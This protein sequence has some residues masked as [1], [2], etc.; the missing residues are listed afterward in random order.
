MLQHATFARWFDRTVIIIAYG[1]ATTM[2]R[3]PGQTNI[4]NVPTRELAVI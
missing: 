4:V 3:L 1:T 2:V